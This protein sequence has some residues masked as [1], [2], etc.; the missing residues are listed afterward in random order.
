[1]RKLKKAVLDDLRIYLEEHYQPEVT[2]EEEISPAPIARAVPTYAARCASASI[3]PP[4]QT[5]AAMHKAVRRSIVPASEPVEN[6]AVIPDLDRALGMLD[7]S[8]QQML[9]RKID[10]KGMKDS[11][12]YKRAGIDRKLFSKIRSNPLYKPKKTTVIAFIMALE[13]SEEEASEML[14]KAGYALS[15]SSRFDV[16]VAYFIS[17]GRYSIREL[18]EALYAYDQP[19]I[20]QE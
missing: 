20:G 8:F 11:A 9:L 4:A 12:C 3:A 13:L 14:T 16:I 19:L 7:E 1:M 17:R 6:T 18:N 2:L 10:E 5:P 15:R